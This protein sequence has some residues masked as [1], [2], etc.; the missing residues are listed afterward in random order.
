MKF[1]KN[2]TVSGVDK[3]KKFTNMSTYLIL[4]AALAAM[5]FFGVC[6]PSSQ[7]QGPQGSA[8][9]V[10][11]EVISRDEFQ[12]TYRQLY[13][14]YKNIYRESFNPGQLQIAGSALQQLVDN[15]TMYLTAQRLGLTASDAEVIK[16]IGEYNIFNDEKG[17]WSDE[18]YEGFLRNYGYTEKSFME[19]IRRNITVGKAR[20]WILTTSYASQKAAEID[21][22]LAET[23]V[24]V[25]YVKVDPQNVNV[26]V[27]PKELDTFL[28]DE[29]KKKKVEDYYSNNERQYQKPEEVSARHI[30]ISFKGA[31]N[32]TGEGAKRSKADAKKK[33]E[34]VLA[35]VKA[36][37]ANF[38]EIA[39]KETDEA[40]GKG[41]GGSL[42]WFSRDAMVKPFSDAAFALKQGEISGVVE[43]PFGF[44]IIKHEGH[45]PANNKTLA[46]VQR[47]IAK[48]L[49]AKERRP[50]VATEQAEAIL[51]KLKSGEAVDPLLGTYKVKWE[52]TGDQPA[53]FRSL[54]GIGSSDEVQAAVLKLSKP[55]EVADTVVDV[56]G[57]KYVLRLKSRK[58]AD[59]AKLDQEKRKEM[60]ETASFQEGNALFQTLREQS[61]KNFQDKIWKN[62]AYLGLDQ[63]QNPEG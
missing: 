21:F 10:G 28:A 56:R 51:A 30:L 1:Q 3:S 33:A 15:R 14:Q 61:S 11:D 35:K 19:D 25:E 5:T 58:D 34:E 29:A 17:N 20:Q 18:A 60:S 44:H 12:R 47:D 16:T 53:N 9:K 45:K 43:S 32:A 50:A 41:S 57:N 8:A 2:H 22:N 24:N 23:T 7:Y 63:A 59:I 48:D 6:D 4:F 42:G 52:A 46:D 55:G 38:V 37:G 31:R 40:A 62:P 54:K 26:D 49:I 36:P 27:A 39:K 13:D